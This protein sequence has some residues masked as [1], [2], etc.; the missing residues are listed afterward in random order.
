MATKANP[1]FGNDF[2]RESVLKQVNTSLSSLQMSS[3]DILYLHGPDHN[4]P[5][6]ETLSACHQ[7]HQGRS[8]FHSFRGFVCVAVKLD[9]EGSN[10]HYF[11]FCL[12][13]PTCEKDHKKICGHCITIH[14]LSPEG[15]FKELGLSNFAAW[16][17]ADVYHTCKRNGWVLP[18]LYQGM[19]NATTRMVESE[20]FPALRYFGLRFYAYNPV[21]NLDSVHGS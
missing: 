7:L 5:I 18:T 3:V 20:L 17:V 6:E 12:T 11:A 15:K 10:T 4:T 9:T 14:S 8:S 19:Y 1:W 2:K 21:S 16:E 13:L